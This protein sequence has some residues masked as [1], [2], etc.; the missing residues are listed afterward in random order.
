MRWESMMFFAKG[1]KEPAMFEDIQGRTE[2]P[3]WWHDESDVFR[4]PLEFIVKSGWILD[5]FY[6]VGTQRMLEL[7]CCEWKMIDVIHDDEIRDLADPRRAI[8]PHRDVADGLAIEVG[9]GEFAA[10]CVQVIIDVP[11]LSLAPVGR[12][13][14][15]ERDVDRVID[16]NTFEGVDRQGAEGRAVGFVERSDRDEHDPIVA[17]RHPF[18]NRPTARIRIDWGQPGRSASVPCVG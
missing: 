13:E 3:E 2:I 11:A 10:G 1:Q 16:R 15:A 5:V 9:H 4:D 14:R 6:R 17:N 12:G 7:I 8:E 18:V